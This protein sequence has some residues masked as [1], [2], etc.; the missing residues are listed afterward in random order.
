[1][2]K[3]KYNNHSEE[4]QNTTEEVIEKEVYPEGNDNDTEK[5]EKSQS[6]RK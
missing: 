6:K 3:K 1:M 2:K 4:T 5:Q